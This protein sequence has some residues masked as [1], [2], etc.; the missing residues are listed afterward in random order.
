MSGLLHQSATM[1]LICSA[2]FFGHE[3]VGSAFN[4]TI[5]QCSISPSVSKSFLSTWSPKFTPIFATPLLLLL[6]SSRLYSCLTLCDAIDGPFADDKNHDLP[7]NHI[8]ILHNCIVTWNQR[9]FCT[10]AAFRPRFSPSPPWYFRPSF[11]ENSCA[12]MIP[13]TGNNSRYWTV[14]ILT[15]STMLYIYTY[16]Y[17]Y[18]YV[19]VYIYIS[20]NLLTRKSPFLI[21][22]IRHWRSS[23]AIL[24]YEKSHRNVLWCQG[25]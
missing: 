17:I 5:K 16:I 6:V 2:A 10:S 1:R 3:V 4:G 19:C 22:Y 23:I 12:M 14:G 18:T 7:I 15:Y 11:A 25:T 13:V 9:V 21:S 8:V 24:Q 20:C